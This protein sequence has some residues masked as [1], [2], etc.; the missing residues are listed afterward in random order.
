MENQ[1]T[2]SCCDAQPAPQVLTP[3]QARERILTL[4]SAPDAYQQVPLKAALQRVLYTDI[5]APIQVPSYDNSAMDG[6]ALHSQD[7][8]VDN[9]VCLPVVGTAWA[10][11]P[12][13]GSLARGQCIRIMTGAKIPTGAD[14]V[15]MQEQVERDGDSI[16]LSGT[17]SAGQNLRYAGEDIAQGETVLHAGHWLQ[18]ADLGLLA[19]LGVAEVRVFRHLRVALLST[20]DE[21]RSPGEALSE[22]AIY[23]SNRYSLYALLQQLGVEILDLGIIH[24]QP[25]AI[26]QALQIAAAQADAVIS[27]GGVSVGDADF[28][29]QIL[30][31]LG[32]IAFWKVAM[33]P[34]H[35]L[36]FGTLGGAKFFGLPGNPVSAM[37]T[38]AQFVRPALQRMMGCQPPAPVRLQAVCSEALR[39][40]PGRVE[41]QRG[42]VAHEQGVLSVRLAGAQG[43]HLLTSMSKANCFIVLPQQ[44]EGVA[45]GE[46]VEIELF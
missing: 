38:F 2:S 21:L 16:R 9:P 19:S 15:I 20:G 29:Q 36:A 8:P 3:D 45:V 26:R 14:T 34:G 37:V 18:P 6:Y 27:S 41:F 11:K 25:L 24:D 7:L 40:R 10:G 17:H 32:Q 23:D 42:I 28:V 22:G 39:K 13:T 30:S 46:R 4:V 44:S 12:F 35:P 5:C 31:E 33:K 43:S 1:A